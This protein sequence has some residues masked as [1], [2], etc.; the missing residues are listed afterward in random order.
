MMRWSPIATVF[1][2]GALAA[3]GEES[4]DPEPSCGAASSGCGT[5]EHCDR[6]SLPARCVCD[7]Q[8][9]GSSCG[10]CAPGYR[11]SG[12]SC[13]T[14]TVLCE[15]RPCGAR[16]QCLD[17]TNG[18]QTCVCDSGYAG[19][20]CATCVDGYQDNDGDGVCQPSC[21][22][23]S[24]VCQGAEA[25]SDASGEA[26]CQCAAGLTGPTCEDC[27]PGYRRDVG[28][29]ACVATCS[30]PDFE[31]DGTCRETLQGALCECEPGHAG[32]DC[33]SCEPTHVQD[34]DGSCVA[35]LPLDAL[36]WTIV[37]TEKASYLGG[38]VPPAFTFSAVVPIA[39]SVT[40]LTAAAAGVLYGLSS[41][42]LVSIDPL[43]GELS[44]L[45]DGATGLGHA[46]TRDPATG[47]LFVA[48]EDAVWLA[49]VGT[50]EVT[51]LSTPGAASIAYDEVRRMLLGVGTDGE[52]FEID[53]GDGTRRTLGPALDLQSF[54][55][56]LA[57]D[58]AIGRAY[59]LGALP[60]LPEDKLERLCSEM[61]ETLGL[62]RT[63]R[64]QVLEF[65]APLAAGE[66]RV[67]ADSGADPPLVAYGSEQGTDQG[68][69]LRVDTRHPDSLICIVTVSERLEVVVSAEATFQLLVVVSDEPNVTLTVE[70]GFSTPGAAIHVR[71]GELTVNGPSER[72]TTYTDEE[73]A[74][75]GLSTWT[76]APE[77]REPLL[78][79]IDWRSGNSA[80]VPLNVAHEM[81]GLSW[82]GQP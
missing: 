59:A 57:V 66:T 71:A 51:E 29:N 45:I 17:G 61:A 10:E 14:V 46:L 21:G 27:E 38:L 15:E 58:P 63:T 16:G 42:A 73:W 41:G 36:L 77:V 39:D 31:C 11:Q 30:A 54:G 43:T 26:R 68:G 72:V 75:L 55:L 56:G 4:P 9:A 49:D 47:I 65:G 33:Q 69:T 25:C 2:L 6:I 18:S 19:N 7:A 52:R 64:G 80:F 35:P 8:Y 81:I 13:S 44:P 70:E 23:A 28:S 34:S 22:V 67:L 50:Q 79:L 76:T 37:R 12:S 53:P 74:A 62:P 78:S 48:S 40:D 24:V 3:C 60:E 82:V 20:F 5:R 32:V 1:A